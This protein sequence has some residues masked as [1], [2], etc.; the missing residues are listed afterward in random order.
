MLLKAFV[1]RSFALCFAL[2]FLFSRAIRRCTSRSWFF[3]SCLASANIRTPFFPPQWLPW[4]AFLRPG[5]STG[6]RLSHL[7]AAE[8]CT[9]FVI[10]CALSPVN[11]ITT[12]PK[13]MCDHASKQSGD[14]SC[15]IHGA[16]LLSTHI[17]PIRVAL[18]LT[19]QWAINRYVSL[20]RSIPKAMRLNDREQNGSVFISITASLQHFFVGVGLDHHAG[21]V[22]GLHQSLCCH[23]RV[24]ILFCFCFCVHQALQKSKDRSRQSVFKPDVW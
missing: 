14:T 3:I 10:A 15:K 19:F 11:Y 18:R 4:L 22:G 21:F 20:S 13:F 17:N 2:I 5:I 9:L 8:T 23:G 6:A 12:P 16:M 1:F 7:D 24:H